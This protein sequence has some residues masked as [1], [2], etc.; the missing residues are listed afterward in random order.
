MVDPIL[1]LA[2][3]LNEA[4]TEKVIPTNVTL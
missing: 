2:N 3:P 1:N 4:K